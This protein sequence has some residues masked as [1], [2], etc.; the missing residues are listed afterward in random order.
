M[1]GIAR[2]LSLPACLEHQNKLLVIVLFFFF[3]FENW[4]AFGKGKVLQ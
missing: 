1:F 3:P 4:K 2:L